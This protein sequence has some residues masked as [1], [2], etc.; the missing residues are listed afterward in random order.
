MYL[1]ELFYP[2]KFKNKQKVWE[3]WVDNG[4]HLLMRRKFTAGVPT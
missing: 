1:F 2:H 3:P 4:T